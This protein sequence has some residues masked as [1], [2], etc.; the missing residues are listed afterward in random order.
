MSV[1]A[2]VQNKSTGSD[3]GCVLIVAAN[4]ARRDDSA[5]A[6]PAN[7]L[8]AG[9]VAISAAEPRRKVKSSLFIIPVTPEVFLNSSDQ[10]RNANTRRCKQKQ[11]AAWAS[12][13]AAE[14]QGGC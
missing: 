8:A 11:T 3:P 10:M 1:S 4:G 6:S 13:R 14:K 9:E 7:T 5:A 2:L 12:E